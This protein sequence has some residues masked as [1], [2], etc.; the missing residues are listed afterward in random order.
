[1]LLDKIVLDAQI[2]QVTLFRDAFAVHD[3]ELGFTEGRGQLVLHHFDLCAIADHCLAFLY[4]SDAA[5]IGADASVELESAASGRRFGVAEHYPN[6]FADLIDE[7]QASIRLR[8]YT[9]E[10]AHSLRHQSGVNA[11]EAIAHLAIELGL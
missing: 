9:G 1:A 5:D 7:D 3:V 6:F 8:H 2:D 10:L 11:H 4:G